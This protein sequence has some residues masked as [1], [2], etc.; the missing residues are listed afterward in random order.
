MLSP[1]TR[2]IPLVKKKG[3]GERC[4]SECKTVTTTMSVYLHIYHKFNNIG[5]CVN[6][7]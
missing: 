7:Q 4:C 1:K 6:V 5:Q 2:L 3:G